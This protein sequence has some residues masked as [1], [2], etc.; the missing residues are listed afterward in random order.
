M[1]IVVASAQGETRDVAT[2]NDALVVRLSVSG[3]AGTV[4]RPKPPRAYA[5]VKA[6]PA[7][8]RRVM[9]G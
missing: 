1:L 9:V 4:D 7:A 2:E 5:P 6:L 8:S 3:V